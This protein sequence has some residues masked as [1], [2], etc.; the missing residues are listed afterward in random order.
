MK[1]VLIITYYWPPSGGAGVQRMLK[2]VKYFS[3]FEIEPIVITV[4]DKKASYQLKDETLLIDIPANLR[5]IKTNTFEPF[6]IYKV[7]VN[8]KEIPHSGF[9]NEPNP[10]LMQKIMRFIR[11]NLFIP[12]ARI[13]WNRYAYKAALQIIKSE[14]IDAIITSSP[15][16]ST[17]IVG[18]KLKK[19]FNIPWIADLRDPWTDIYFYN[20]LFHTSLAK[21]IDSN[22]EKKVLENA[23]SIVV[24]SQDIKRIFTTKSNIINEDKIIVLPNGFDEDDF[25][26]NVNINPNEFSIT[27]TGTFADIYKIDGFLAAYKKLIETNKDTTIKLKFIGMI[28]ESLPKKIKKLNLQD[29]VS[30]ENYVPHKESIKFLQKSS[31]LLLVI[32]KM[33]K[34]EGI[35]TGKLFE[36]L[37]SGKPILCVGPPKGDAAAIIN[38]CNAGN[39][40]DYNDENNMIN[41][42]EKNLKYWKENRTDKITNIII[43]KYSR[44]NLTKELSNIINKFTLK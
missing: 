44:K 12:D 10:G 35:L 15:P 16:H 2:F 23:D 3:Q 20:K 37:G 34:N 8:K 25:S 19:K 11:G 1:K 13:G 32:P 18:L 9:A 6:E 22:Y 27:Y 26:E 33:D 42:L 41:F 14:K 4:D 7:L 43:D 28:S 5:I 29:H 31:I 30:F 24:V 40:F 21:K 39:V 36:Y 17:Q 38:E